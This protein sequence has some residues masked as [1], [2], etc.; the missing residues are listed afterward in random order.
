MPGQRWCRR[1]GNRPCSPH[2][3]GFVEPCL[4]LL[5]AAGPNHGYELAQGLAEFGLDQVDPSI[6]YRVLRT[7]EETGLIVSDWQTEGTQG[8]ARRAYQITQAGHEATAAWVDELQATAH[9]LQHFL[10]TYRAL[11]TRETPETE[12]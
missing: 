7:M 8:P 6:V 12:R 5:L 2:I 10:E 11:G 1:H 9:V 4:L 3:R